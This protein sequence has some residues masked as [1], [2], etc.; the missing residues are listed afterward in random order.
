MTRTALIDAVR[1]RIDEVSSGASALVNVGVE[2]N[3][4]TDTMIGSLLDEAALEVLQTAPLLR[5]PIADGHTAT[6]TADSADTKIGEIALPSN[7]LRIVC[8]Q[9]S[10]W[11]RP[12]YNIEPEGSIVA[13][14]QKNVYLRG[15]ATKP[16]AVL[17]KRP[18]GYVLC[19]FSTEAAPHSI[20]RLDYV[21]VLTA[22]NVTGEQ[23]IDALCWVCAAKVLTITQDTNAA[24]AAMEHA[25]SLLK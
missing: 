3:N 21:P 1:V 23:N 16:V 4:P 7:F 6:L 11:K 25:R 15:K 2:E 10:D 5:L 12:V 9:M 22:E 20:K 17:E 14:R 24:A 8:L 19:Y 13:N 18:S